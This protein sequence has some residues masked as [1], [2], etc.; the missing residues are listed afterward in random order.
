MLP[1]ISAGLLSKI[2]HKHPRRSGG[3]NLLESTCLIKPRE[4][5]MKNLILS[6]QPSPGELM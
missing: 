5:K 4:S 1:T 2:R 3:V 6:N